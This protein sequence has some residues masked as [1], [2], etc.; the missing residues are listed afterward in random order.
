MMLVSLS[1]YCQYPL[2][3]TIG[4]D[5]VVVMTIKQG[6]DINKKFGALEDSIVTAKAQIAAL[7]KQLIDQKDTF[8]I[9]VLN[10]KQTLEKE[11]EVHQT[12]TKKLNSLLWTE[13][14]VARRHSILL[15]VGVTIFTTLISTISK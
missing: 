10:V 6:E 5:T 12:E 8:N 7:N 4:K 1:S 2:V 3:K 15:L 11:K 13:A 14:K 9:Q